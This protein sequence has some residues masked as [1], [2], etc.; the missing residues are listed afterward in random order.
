VVA[1]EEQQFLARQQQF[2]AQGVTPQ[3]GGGAGMPSGQCKE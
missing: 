1:E 2:L 3:Q